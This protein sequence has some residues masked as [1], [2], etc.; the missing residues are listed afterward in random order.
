MAHRISKEMMK[1]D[2]IY[3]QDGRGSRSLADKVLSMSLPESTAAKP[4]AAPFQGA[5]WSI[6]P[7]CK[8][9]AK[10]F[11]VIP[12]EIRHELFPSPELSLKQLTNFSLP[13]QCD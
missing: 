6:P 5:N 7:C 9:A 1:M 8:G 2:V 12:P 13:S 3:R 10:S 11:V 4:E